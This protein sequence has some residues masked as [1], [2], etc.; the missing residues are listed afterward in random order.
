[1]KTKLNN[2]VIIAI[3][4]NSFSIENYL[5][6][7]ISYIKSHLPFPDNAK[8]N[9][10]KC[11]LNNKTYMEYRDKLRKHLK[12]SGYNNRAMPWII[13]DIGFAHD[14]MDVFSIPDNSLAIEED[15]FVYPDKEAE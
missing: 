11:W 12:A 8:L 13:L 10:S 7:I 6:D 1:M 3:D 4:L 5:N 9:V 2:P 15:C 14:R